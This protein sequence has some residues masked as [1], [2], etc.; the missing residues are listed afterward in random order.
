MDD[1]TKRWAQGV[2]DSGQFN[3][4][5]C[6][7]VAIGPHGELLAAGDDLETVRRQTFRS[8]QLAI[9]QDQITVYFV[10]VDPEGTET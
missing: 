10:D 1:A 7:H 5:A 6:R 4:V 3:G 9:E 2:V 8:A